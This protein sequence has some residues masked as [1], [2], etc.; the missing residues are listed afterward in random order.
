MPIDVESLY[1]RYGPM[2]LRRCRFLLKNEQKAADAMHEVFIQLLRRDGLA[3]EAPASF[4]H[5][6]ATNVCLNAL[7][8]DRRHPEDADDDLIL[9]IARAPEAE[10]H[11]LA[12]ALLDRLFARQPESS[13]TIAVLHLVDGMTHEEVAAEVGMSVSGVRKRLAGLR[14]HLRELEEQA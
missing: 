4:L 2:V 10:D 9:R 6:T 3:I 11:T 13:R 8:T 1:R 12:A 14:T 5:R 7:R